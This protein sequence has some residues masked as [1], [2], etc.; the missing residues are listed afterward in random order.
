MPANQS[1]PSAANG[2]RPAMHTTPSTRSGSTAAQASAC[3]PP[4]EAPK[5]ANVSTPS[6]SATLEVSAA[7]EATSRSG[8]RV[9]PP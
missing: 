1:S 4:P 6:A 7:I 3:G 8:S 2:A 5:T 9:D